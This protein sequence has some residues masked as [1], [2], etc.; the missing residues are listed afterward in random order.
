MFLKRRKGRV[1]WGKVCDVGLLAFRQVGVEVREIGADPGARVGRTGVENVGT[2]RPFG[3]TR[4]GELRK[5]RE[6][7]P[8]NSA[9]M[10]F[11]R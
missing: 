4:L 9:V 1:K 7:F 11:T 3:L 10:F 6:N 5:M 8:E 2:Y